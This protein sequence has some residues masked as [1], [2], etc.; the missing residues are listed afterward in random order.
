MT[1][2]AV[3]ATA[4]NIDCAAGCVAPANWRSDSTAPVRPEP[5]SNWP[6]SAVP[7]VIASASPP[8]TLARMSGS[9]AETASETRRAP[10]G[11][12]AI[13]VNAASTV[14][15]AASTRRP[16]VASFRPAAR[17]SVATACGVRTARTAS[18]RSIAIQSPRA[19]RPPPGASRHFPYRL[20]PR[21][22]SENPQ[23]PSAARG[24]Q[25]K[26][27]A[28]IPAF[29]G[30]EAEMHDVAVGDDIVLALEPEL[31]GLPRARFAAKGHIVLVSDR[32]GANE[33][34]LE[35]A[36]DHAGRLGGL[37]A[38]LDRPGA[39]LLW[40]RGEERDEAEGG[41]ARADDAVEAGLAQ[42]DSG[43]I[44][45]LLGLR[46]DRDLGLDLRRDDDRRRAL[47]LGLRRHH[48]R[49]GV[50]G[51]GRGLVDVADIKNG[52]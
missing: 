35:I 48:L 50:A 15:I 23:I 47:L 10:P 31:A 52:L 19:R 45:L 49:I 44:F 46:Q 6:R 26:I 38:L 28:E 14:G 12:A 13:V 30:G 7:R 20:R 51:V 4:P 17:A 2:I 8:A 33:A 37:G 43:E 39:R 41:V 22:P 21:K 3:S 32:L 16:A 36:M 1:P 24:R 27:S 42:A 11:A 18:T 5:P 40:A 34:A 29:S 9:E 25:A